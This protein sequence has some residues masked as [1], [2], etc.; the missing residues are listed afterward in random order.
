MTLYVFVSGYYV[1]NSCSRDGWIRQWDVCHQAL[2]ENRDA[3]PESVVPTHKWYCG[4]KH[5]CNTA[6]DISNQDD[7][8]FISSCSK[9]KTVLLWDTREDNFVNQIDTE[10]IGLPGAGGM[11]TS[12]LYTHSSASGGSTK[13]KASKDSTKT[14]NTADSIVNDDA[15]Q[16]SGY[17]IY[18]GFEGGIIALMDRR[19]LNRSVVCV[20]FQ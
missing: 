20:I 18:I 2:H 17:N 5:F 14:G 15:T 16:G 9:E 4:M 8:T 12:L 7:Y 19:V 1:V 3:G 13:K 6:T 11:V 10:S